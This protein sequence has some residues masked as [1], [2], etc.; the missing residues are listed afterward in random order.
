MAATMT[1]EANAKLQA[2]ADFSTSLSSANW[3]TF[4]ELAEAKFC[5]DTNYDWISDWASLDANIKKSASLAV[6]CLTANMAIKYDFS[7]YFS[8]AN[9][10]SIMSYNDD[11]YAALIKRINDD[12]I[13]QLLGASV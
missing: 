2:G 13:R 11:T 10:Q 9:A 3:V 7:T 5:A 4:I 12:D 8:L 6:D 1:T